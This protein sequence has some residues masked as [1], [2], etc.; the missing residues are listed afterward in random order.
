MDNREGFVVRRI[1]AFGLLFVGAFLLVL[2]LGAQVYAEDRLERTP[3]DVHSVTDLAGTAELSGPDGLETVPVQVTSTTVTD[4]EASDDEVA[5]WKNS[6]CVVRDEGDPP[7]CVSNDDPEKRLISASEDE[8]ATDRVTALAVENPEEYDVPP[9]EGLINKFPF[10]AE[11]TTYPY[12]ES[13]LQRAVDAVYDRTEDMDGVE[14]YVYTVTTTD[15]QIE[16]ADGVEGLYSD[17]KEIWVEPTTG[18]ILNQAVS[19]ERTTLDG[20]PVLSIEYEFT[21]EQKAESV[22]KAKDNIRSLAL[23]TTWVPIIGYVGGAV[24]LIAGAVLLL[25]G[26][27]RSTAP[28]ATEPRAH[29]TV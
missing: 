11:K 2:A 22:A 15:E 27:R 12:W 13:T 24:C 8:F 21:D 16:I 25:T 4:S 1:V 28:A 17:S 26:R 14:V 18:D 29:A 3:L 20:E 23:L 7:S 5:V 6:S 19:Q 10:G 9:H